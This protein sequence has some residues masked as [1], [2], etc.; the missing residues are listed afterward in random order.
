MSYAYTEAAWAIGPFLDTVAETLVLQFLADIA[1][2]NGVCCPRI[3]EIATCTHLNCKMV[4]NAIKALE[5]NSII[6]CISQPGER[7]RYK[8]NIVPS[9][10]TGSRGQS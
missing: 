2:D 7:K 3:G 9:E 8:L 5:A 10:G 1:N 4:V 6:N